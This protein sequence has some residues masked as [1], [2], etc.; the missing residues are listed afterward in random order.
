MGRYTGISGLCLQHGTGVSIDKRHA[1]YY[2]KLTAYQGIAA[3]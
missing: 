2:L 1:A 3:V